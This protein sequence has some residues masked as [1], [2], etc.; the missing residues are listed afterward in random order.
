MGLCHKYSILHLV[1][2]SVGV[3]TESAARQFNCRH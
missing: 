1:M 2:F 3:E